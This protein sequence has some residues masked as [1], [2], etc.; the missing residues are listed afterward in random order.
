L[1]L[2]EGANGTA[3]VP[4]ALVQRIPLPPQAVLTLFS[5][6]TVEG[7]YPDFFKVHVRYINPEVS[8][9]LD[10]SVPPIITSTVILV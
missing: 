3:E 10:S 6:L 1:C 2:G 7:N 8:Y 9:P 4:T 5:D